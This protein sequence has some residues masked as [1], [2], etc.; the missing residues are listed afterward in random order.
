MTK[1]TVTL[2]VDVEV[3]RLDEL[4]QIDWTEV[5][6]GTAEGTVEADLEEILV[7]A[8]TGVMLSGASAPEPVP[9]AVEFAVADPIWKNNLKKLSEKEDEEMVSLDETE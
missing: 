4:V 7:E 9:H 6:N 8:V 5:R 2:E 3:E 1:G